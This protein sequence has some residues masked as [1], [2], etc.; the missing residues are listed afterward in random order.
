MNEIYVMQRANKDLF[1]FDDHGRF[2]VPLFRTSHD[3][4][5]ARSRNFEMLLFKPVVLDDRLL[6]E[7]EAGRA[8]VDLW[9]IN[10]PLLGPKRGSLIDQAQLVLLLYGPLPSRDVSENGGSL[11]PPLIGAFAQSGA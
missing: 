3:A 7:L 11:G 2:G 10:D 4:M 8:D 5:I 6:S 9:L 1:A